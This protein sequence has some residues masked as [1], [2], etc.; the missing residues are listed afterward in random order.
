MR[1]VLRGCYGVFRVWRVFSLSGTAQ[2]ELKSERVYAPA[3]GP[4]TPLDWSFPFFLLTPSIRSSSPT[5][6]PPPRTPLLSPTPLR[7]DRLP[8]SADAHS[9][10]HR[11]GE[12]PSLHPWL[13]R[14]LAHS[15]RHPLHARASALGSRFIGFRRTSKRSSRIPCGNRFSPPVTFMTR[16]S[17]ENAQ[18]TL[19]LQRAAVLTDAQ[20]AFSFAACKPTRT[21]TSFVIAPC[22]AADG[23]SA[24]RAA[25]RSR[26]EQSVPPRLPR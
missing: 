13:T 16:R 11:Q 25:R 26:A 3:S 14:S 19:T 1:H 15:P 5:P 8:S 22:R 2:V 18:K 9:N 6:H 12:R 24:R 21:R 4:S 17:T 23:H 10:T 7:L 20:S